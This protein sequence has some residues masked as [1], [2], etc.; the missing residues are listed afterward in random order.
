MIDY[1]SL[2]LSHAVLL[3]AFWR[4]FGRDDLDRDPPPEKL[5]EQTDDAE[6]KTARIRPLRRA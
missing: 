5:P 1:L 2:G 4:L 6:K 3:L